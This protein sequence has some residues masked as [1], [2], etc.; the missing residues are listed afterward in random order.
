MDLKEVSFVFGRILKWLKTILLCLAGDFKQKD[1]QCFLLEQSPTINY[2]R[3]LDS[4][5]I[6]FDLF[7]S[8]HPNL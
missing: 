5:N 3:I 1:W 2:I 4:L 8:Q 6:L 7:F